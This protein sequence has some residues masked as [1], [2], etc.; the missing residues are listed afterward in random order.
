MSCECHVMRYLQY[1]EQHDSLAKAL[2]LQHYTRYGDHLI[3]VAQSPAGSHNVIYLLLK[4]WRQYEF[5]IIKETV[6]IHI[7][8]KSQ[9]T[10]NYYMQWLQRALNVTCGLDACMERKNL[11]VGLVSSLDNTSFIHNPLHTTNHTWIH[12]WIWSKCILSPSTC[13]MY[14]RKSLPDSQPVQH[15]VFSIH[16]LSGSQYPSVILWLLSEVEWPACFVR[17]SP[18]N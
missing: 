14:L 7:V 9:H 6:K 3:R 1:I 5:C 15:Y 10:W 17:G 2:C 4:L 11:G 16:P 13:Y 8:P 18:C 12:N